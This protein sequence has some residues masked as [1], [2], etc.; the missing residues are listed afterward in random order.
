MTKRIDRVEGRAQ[1]RHERLK[2]ELADT[3]S[4]AKSDQAQLVQNTDQC[5]VESL[6]PATKKPEERDRRMT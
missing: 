6:A 1:Q 3:K 5:L 4:K 2:D